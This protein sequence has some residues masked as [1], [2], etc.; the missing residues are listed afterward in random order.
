MERRNSKLKLGD[1]VS[2]PFTI[3]EQEYFKNEA[4]GDLWK[5]RQNTGRKIPPGT[6][7]T[8]VSVHTQGWGVEKFCPETNKYE[9]ETLEVQWLVSVDFGNDFI[10]ALRTE[11]AT[12]IKKAPASS[13]QQTY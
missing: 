1:K 13:S 4:L 7:G 3:Y 9:T 2:F 5:T 12:L 11:S 10:E 6:I 8:V